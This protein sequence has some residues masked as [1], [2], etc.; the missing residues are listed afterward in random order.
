MQ[1]TLVKVNGQIETLIKELT[2]EPRLREDSNII[3]LTSNELADISLK[4]SRVIRKGLPTDQLLENTIKVLGEAGIAER[5]L[6]FQINEDG[7]KALLTHHWESPYV[8]NF[9]PVGFQLDLR[10]APLFKLFHLNESRTLQIEDF[11]KYLALPNYLFRN[12]FKALFIKLKTKSLLVTTGST[13]KIR[14]A[15]NL[16]F[17]TRDVIWSNEIEK[18]LQSILD[19][20]TL[21]IEQSSDKRKKES[22]QRNIIQLQE[23]A[24]REQEELLKQFASD[25]HDLPCSIIPN[26]KSAIREKDFLE[27]ERL[28][29]ELHNNLRQLINEYVVPDISLLGFG[30]TIY[31]FIN[32]FKKTFGGK[33]VVEMPNEEIALSQ[34]TAFELFKVIKEWFCNIEKHSEATEIHFNLKKL[35][36]CYFLITIRDNGK[37]F[38]VKNTRNLGYGILNIR[39][40]LRDINSKFEIQSEIT[41]GSA[42]KIQVSVE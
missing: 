23:R 9:N 36:D 35:N 20:L 6:L 18:V 25:V 22:L 19:Q 28:V 37:G 4:I 13:G 29:D 2:Y 40:R 1:Q 5:V 39:R 41:K 12:K 31:Q 8:P 21:A 10:D 24:I 17:C 3:L 33:V 7:T 34:R 14:V 42:L 32:G 27:S 30:S 11:S 38:D 16:Q 26:L 15:L